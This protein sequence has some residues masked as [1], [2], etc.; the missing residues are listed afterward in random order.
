MLDTG[1]GICIL[2]QEGLLP[3]ESSVYFQTWQG[4][5]EKKTPELFRWVFSIS[6]HLY[7]SSLHAAAAAKSL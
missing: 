2:R 1:D 6:F 7:T 3:M 5:L 4:E